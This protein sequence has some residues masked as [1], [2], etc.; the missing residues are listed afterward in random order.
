MASTSL[1]MKRQMGRAVGHVALKILINKWQYL[2]TVAY[3]DYVTM[4]G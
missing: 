4:E 3:G 1:W 2:E